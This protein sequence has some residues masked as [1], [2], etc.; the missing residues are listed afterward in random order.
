MVKVL[1]RD[2]IQRMV[3]G[4]GGNISQSTGGGSGDGVSQ[5]WVNANFVSIAYFEQLFK[6]YKPGESLAILM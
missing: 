3:D 5:A 6:A 2:K 4:S 1:N